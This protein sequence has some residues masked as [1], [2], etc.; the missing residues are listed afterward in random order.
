MGII[1]NHRNQSRR[2]GTYTEPIKK[3]TEKVNSKILDLTYMKK[4]I[5]NVMKHHVT[6]ELK[7]STKGNRTWIYVQNFRLQ[8]LLG[9]VDTPT[10][11]YMM[12]SML[13]WCVDCRA[14]VQP[15]GKWEL[16]NYEQKVEV[17]ETHRSQTVGKDQ[18]GR[19]QT[20]EL[21]E[22]IQYLVIGMEF[23][24][25][26]GNGDLQYDMGRV[27][28]GGEAS[29]TPKMLKE[30][31]EN[32][33]SRQVQP[34][35]DPEMGKYK[36]TMQVQQEKIAQQDASLLE[37]KEQMTTMQDMMAGLITELQTARNSAI[38]DEKP[39]PKRRGK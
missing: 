24:D 18:D 31:L 26:N 7:S 33:G 27:K 20:I 39:K 30:L 38:V 8:N 4:M 21:A 28:S 15:N 1:S 13:E 14:A 3:D 35:P 37:M 11:V 23:V 5:D 32:Q 34:V 10:F 2:L 19:V 25:I 16:L 29:L 9:R 22:D 12:E 6:K 36:E 17:I